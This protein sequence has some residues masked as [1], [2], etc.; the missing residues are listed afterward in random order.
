MLAVGMGATLL[1]IG[2][3]E[4]TVFLECAG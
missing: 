1:V 4:G 3:R 2:A